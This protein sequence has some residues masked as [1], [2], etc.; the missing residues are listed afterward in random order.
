ME[1]SRKGR[2]NTGR[3][4]APKAMK[5]PEASRKDRKEDRQKRGAEGHIALEARRKYSK[6][7]RQKRGPEGCGSPGSKSERQKRRQAEEKP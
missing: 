1:A 6:T 2:R 4:E 5:A 3:R 7:V